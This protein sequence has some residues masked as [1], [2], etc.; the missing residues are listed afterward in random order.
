MQQISNKWNNFE[1]YDRYK[2]RNLTEVC[3][4][5]SVLICPV[6]CKRCNTESEGIEWIA[7]FPGSYSFKCPNCDN[8]I[9]IQ[10]GM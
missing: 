5:P 4:M 3:I 2:W 1:E 9:L 6:K 7:K 10:D 8:H